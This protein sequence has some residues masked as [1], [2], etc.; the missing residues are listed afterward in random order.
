MQNLEVVLARAWPGWLK[1]I[2]YAVL[3][4][5][6]YVAYI[7]PGPWIGTVGWVLGIVYFSLVILYE[8]VAITYF[9]KYVLLKTTI[10]FIAL[11]KDG[12]FIDE[13]GLN[14]RED[15]VDESSTNGT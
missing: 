13:D 14:I 4:V 15:K 7:V 11:Q 5:A 10:E 3:V 8:H 6:C 9:N 2:N 12:T 1:A